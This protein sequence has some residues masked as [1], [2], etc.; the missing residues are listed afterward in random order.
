MLI[1]F[2]G[3]LVVCEHV[4]LW[5]CSLCSGGPPWSSFCSLPTPMKPCTRC[6][7]GHFSHTAS[8]GQSLSFSS[9]SAYFWVSNLYQKWGIHSFP[10]Q[11]PAALHYLHCWSN[12]SIP[13]C[14]LNPTYLLH[15]GHGKEMASFHYASVLQIFEGCYHPLHSPILFSFH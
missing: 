7:T 6:H 13:C 12:L 10:T 5:A 15:H 9:L 1:H 3:E 14:C 11:P 8:Q 2:Q 4:S